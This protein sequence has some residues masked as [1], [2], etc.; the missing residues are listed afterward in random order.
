MRTL[1]FKEILLASFREKKARRV[2]FDPRLTV[3]RGNNETGKSCLLKSIFRTFG[4]EPARVHPNWVRSEVASLVRFT[5]DDQLF[6]VLRHG[7]TYAVFNSS[8]EPLGRFQSVTNGLGPFLSDLV[9]FGM[10]LP[11][12]DGNLTPLPPAYYFLPFY[13]DQD[14][15]WS[16]PWAAFARLEQFANW[17]RAVAE[18]HA[19][20][21]GS[22][23]YAAQA[24]KAAAE[25]SRAETVRRS[26]NFREVYAKLSETFVPAKFSMDFSSY[27]ADVKELLGKCDALREREESHKA[28]LAE[29]W[30]QRASLHAQLA[31]TLLARDESERDFEYASLSEEDEVACPTCGAHYSNS[32]AER[33][34]IA[35]DEDRCAGLALHLSHEIAELDRRIAGEEQRARATRVELA[36]LGDTLAQAQEGVALRDLIRSEGRRELREVVGK[37]TEEL[38]ALEI[39]QSAKIRSAESRMRAADG[40][41]KRK[42]VNAFYKEALETYLMDL[43]VHSVPENARAKVHATI[44]STGSE[45][46][47]ALLAAHVALFEVVAKFG[48]SAVAPLVLDSPNQQ[49]QD[50]AHEERI[51]QFIRARCTGE[52]QVIVAMVNPGNVPFQ[53]TQI[54]LDRRYSL[55]TAEAFSS[56]GA[57]LQAMLEQVLRG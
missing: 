37:E 13:M 8:D 38:N 6:S 19:G 18:Y 46:P 44:T 28:E 24:E 12:R 50:R 41:G 14:L 16:R 1:R 52:A 7:N 30:S 10:R 27:E 20:I 57:E 34:A 26:E 40:R 33:F 55:L 49:D 25:K 42:Q 36:G 15:S 54:V 11:G 17:R 9:G 32:F 4:A 48:S 56:V 5:V 3:I 23:Y 29:L 51:L 31:I 45:L 53:G 43:D 39:A 21:R 35:V 47:R 2:T 22:D